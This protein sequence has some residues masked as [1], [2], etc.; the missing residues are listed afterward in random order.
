M[1]DA[2]Q[3]PTTDPPKAD[4]A[5]PADPQPQPQPKPAAVPSSFTA[6]DAT[7][8]LNAALCA[9][10]QAAPWVEYTKPEKDGGISYEYLSEEDIVKAL[11]PVLP[12]F[13]L[14]V[15]PRGMAVLFKETYTARS[16]G[17]MVNLLIQVT[18]R[19]VHTS[20]EYQDG[21]ALGE[22]SDSG[23]KAANKA[24]TGAY[25]YFLRELVMVAAGMDPDRTA[26]E[27]LARAEKRGPAPSG[28]GG[29]SGQ[30]KASPPKAASGDGKPT[31]TMEQ[32]LG[33]ALAHVA[34]LNSHDA[35][36]AA[37]EQARTKVFTGADHKDKL[38]KVYN[39]CA[40]RATLL[41]VGEVGKAADLEAV[42]AILKRAEADKI[43]A[44][45][46]DKLKAAAERRQAAIVAEAGGGDDQSGAEQIHDGAEP[47]PLDF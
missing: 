11:R 34:K 38:T 44:A 14:A 3:T 35:I 43:G 27:Q 4:P 2:T 15:I 12:K 16:G 39:A 37:A 1:A 25:K 7:P 24:M 21:Q 45:N 42:D 36:K 41:F 47:E 33:D 13:G 23:D 17:R 30:T 29:G 5:K 9:A 22:G 6:A 46:M 40:A 18:Y 8:N 10:V 32:R 19:L 20:G 31:K 28:T 26:S